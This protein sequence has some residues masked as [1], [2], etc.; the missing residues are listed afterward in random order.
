MSFFGKENRSFLNTLPTLA[1]G[2]KESRRPTARSLSGPDVHMN[3]AV[4]HLVSDRSI[5]GA[6]SSNH[7]HKLKDRTKIGRTLRMIRDDPK[8]FC[9]GRKLLSTLGHRRAF[10][11]EA[12]VDAL[13]P[14]L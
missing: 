10:N 13:Q 1:H 4:N 5:D 7:L 2:R 9:T 14:F 6:G 3:T 8:F 11:S 12:F